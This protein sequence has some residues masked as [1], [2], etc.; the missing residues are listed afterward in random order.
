MMMTLLS[1]LPMFLKLMLYMLGKKGS[2]PTFGFLGFEQ[3]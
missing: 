1:G 3:V 2:W